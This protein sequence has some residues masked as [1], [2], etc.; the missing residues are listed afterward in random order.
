M[1]N[2]CEYIEKMLRT[3]YN[4]TSR[5]INFH[6]EFAKKYMNEVKKEIKDIHK[7]DEK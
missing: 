7:N 3:T 2:Y 6:F 4:F 5:F 1:T